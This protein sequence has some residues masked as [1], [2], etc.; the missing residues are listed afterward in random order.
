MRYRYSCDKSKQIPKIQN[1]QSS[2]FASIHLHP[3]DLIQVVPKINH[4]HPEPWKPFTIAHPPWQHHRSQRWKRAASSR[5]PHNGGSCG[6]V[7]R[8]RH[9]RWPN[10]KRKISH[11]QIGD[12]EVPAA[13][14]FWWKFSQRP[15]N[16]G[17]SQFQPSCS[18]RV[19]LFCFTQSCAQEQKVKN[20]GHHSSRLFCGSA[21]P[22]FWPQVRDPR[23]NSGN[24]SIGT[25]SEIDSAAYVQCI[26]GGGVKLY[27]LS[28]WIIP[29][30]SNY[31]NL[32][33][34]KWLVKEGEP[35]HHHLHHSFGPDRS[36]RHAWQGRIWNKNHLTHAS[37][38]LYTHH[39]G[40]EKGH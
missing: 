30:A 25:I 29:F 19:H 4:Q 3:L 12:P 14:F 27:T 35:P 23:N 28:N 11:Q 7:T 21:P 32:S 37:T 38:N 22:L 34:Q 8:H 17:S 1:S 26:I 33:F 5:P 39:L 9:Q 31:L 36:I 13:S 40:F 6:R 2:S 18:K 10:V 24:I 15:S 16:L 20:R